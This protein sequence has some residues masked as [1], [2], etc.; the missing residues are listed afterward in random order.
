MTSEPKPYEIAFLLKNESEEKIVS[1]LDEIKKYIENKNGRISEES[2]P[3][4]RRLAYPIKKEHEAY[5]GYIKFF[6]K[7][8]ELKEVE[9]KI[10]HNRQILRHTL[11]LQ[12][13]YDARPRPIRRK[14]KRVPEKKAADLAE[15]D[16]KLEEILGK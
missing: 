10:R 2:R 5:F 11:T 1:V 16:K 7:P 4:K 6:S 3:Q 15:I 12:S 13:R 14:I 8:E 9:E